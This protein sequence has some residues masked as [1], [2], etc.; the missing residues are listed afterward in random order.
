MNSQTFTGQLYD[1]LLYTLIQEPAFP[2]E[3][4][5]KKIPQKITE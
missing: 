3:S 5:E 4:V 2:V 1:N